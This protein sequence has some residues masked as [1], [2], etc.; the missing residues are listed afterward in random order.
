MRQS[1]NRKVQH[2]SSAGN[3]P[4]A[5]ANADYENC[6]T[7]C[8]E[9]QSW[10]TVRLRMQGPS[11]TAKSSMA[12]TSAED[13]VQLPSGMASKEWKSQVV[14]YDPI[15]AGR[16]RSTPQHGNTG[17]IQESRRVHPRKRRSKERAD[18][19]ANVVRDLE[20]LA[21]KAGAEAS[22]GLIPQP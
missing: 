7:S 18:A 3:S 6:D 5:A 1:A 21:A 12:D 19:V 2:G 10:E 17:T 20:L 9:S 16:L 8:N 14:F 4:E 22:T 11:Q 13:L 15:T